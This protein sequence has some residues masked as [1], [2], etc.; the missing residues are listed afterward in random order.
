MEPILTGEFV[1]SLMEDDL[2][3]LI[4]RIIAINLIL[5]K[6]VGLISYNET[7]LK[8]MLLNGKTTLSTDFKLMGTMEAELIKNKKIVHQEV[9]F[10]ITLFPSI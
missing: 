4:E 9:P 5:G 7:L 1:I 6:D 3:M 2:V 8:K 10:Y